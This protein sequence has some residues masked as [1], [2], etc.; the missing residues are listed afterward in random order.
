MMAV[1]F[2]S[3]WVPWVALPDHVKNW[4]TVL[5]EEGRGRVP[6]TPEP[7]P[8]PLPNGPGWQSLCVKGQSDGF[9]P[10]GAC[11]LCPCFAV[12]Q[13][14]A[15]GRLSMTRHGRVLPKRHEIGISCNFLIS[16]NV[17]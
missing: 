4:T 3:C 14:A 8:S 1:S 16:Q 9:M 7:A 11:S 15:G 6:A 12:V 10:C 13:T 17:L 5:S 2:V